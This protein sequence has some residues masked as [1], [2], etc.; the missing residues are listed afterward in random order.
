MSD[1]KEARRRLRPA[2][3]GMQADV[4]N[5]L[6]AARFRPLTDWM[7]DWAGRAL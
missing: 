1:R 2:L 3:A 7:A 6:T 4:E 5:A